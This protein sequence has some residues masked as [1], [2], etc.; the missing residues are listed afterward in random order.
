M[1]FS[2][3]MVSNAE[4]FGTKTVILAPFSFSGVSCGHDDFAEV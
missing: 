1:R 3:S 4:S 2:S